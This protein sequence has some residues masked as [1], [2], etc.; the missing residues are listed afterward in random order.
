MIGPYPIRALWR[1][2]RNAKS[3]KER[4]DT[5]YFAWEAS[6]RLGVA[7]RP[8]AELGALTMPS[9]G[10]WV[11]AL[12]VEDRALDN[13]AL[14]ATAALMTE[15]AQGK[16]S[17][18]HRVAARKLLDGLA[19]YRNAII[20]H[21]ST[22]TVEF[23]D[24]AARRLL[25][26]LER[27]WALGLFL[28]ADA[29]LCFV[30]SVEL[31]AGGD[32]RGRVFDL[33][34]D[35]PLLQHAEG[36]R[37]APDVLPGRLYLRCGDEHRP[38]HPWLLYEAAELRE[39]VLFFNGRAR[40]S[41][42][43]DYVGGENLKGKALVTRFPAVE[44]D[45]A[46]LFSSAPTRAPAEASEPKDPNVFGEYRL[47][48][49]LGQGGMGVVYLAQQQSLGRLVALKVQAAETLD[50]PVARARFDREV[51]ALSRCD[52]PNVVKILASG[53]TDGKPYYVMELV[54]GADL[55]QLAA[56][57][58]S[59]RTLDAAITTAAGGV[60]E[61]KH[62]AFADVPVV[63]RAAPVVDASETPARR[64][65]GLCLLFRDA[66]RALDALHAAGVLHRDIKPAN[67]MVT[68]VDRRVVVIDLGLA[69][70]SD[71][72]RG[73]TQ[74]QGSLLGTLR[75]MAPEQLQR[76]LL[77]LDPRADLY[78]L[79]ATFYELFTSR[80]FHDGTTEAQLVEQ[81]LYQAPLAPRKANAAIPVDLATI[82]E[83][84][85]QKDRGQRYQTAAALERDIEAFLQGRP[86]S[87]RRPTLFYRASLA[88]R[89]NKGAILVLAAATALAVGLP[90]LH[91][92]LTPHACA[93]GDLADCTVQCAKHHAGSCYTL[94]TMV[95][96]GSAA[97]RDPARA[98]QLF[99]EACDGGSGP[100]CHRLG[101]MLERGDAGPRDDAEARGR[102]ERA[103][104]LGEPQGCTSLAVLLADGRGGPVDEARA[105]ALYNQACEAHDRIACSNLGAH[106]DRGRGVAAD[107][108]RARAL[109][110]KA[111][112]AGWIPSCAILAVDYVEGRGGP[113][114]EAQ[115]ATLFDRACAAGQ[116]PACSG[117]AALKERGA[118]TAKD[119]P[120]AAELYRRACE[121]EPRACFALGR[122]YERGE[123]VGADVLR[124]IGLFARVC[125]AS[126]PDG[127]AELG[128]LLV[129]GRGIPRDLLHGTELLRKG[130][131]G[132]VKTACDTLAKVPRP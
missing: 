128:V 17:A 94:G 131:E 121:G 111:C 82:L 41:Q 90:A 109:H 77:G 92:R 51:R 116:L 2:A 107:P 102:H 132:G 91:T 103:C 119:L 99:R 83:K 4:H 30:E 76:S 88:A 22:R 31:D 6:V 44:E 127:C 50:D 80:P 106:Y 72:S 113:R 28:P 75:Y 23:Y 21:G 54:E 118:G 61:A 24:D 38:L 101:T 67:L 29:R 42:Y 63:A 87:A 13:P 130:C 47:L 5:A 78:S 26:G 43:L 14:I 36:Q 16:A 58:G 115:A 62:T 27:A 55:A 19:A 112:G 52:H 40:S 59:A 9:T 69:A 8:P 18:P 79:G 57:L 20:G 124:A 49:K 46:A 7:A 10:H 12:Q 120:G 60:R 73:L 56:A 104:S 86:I 89:R 95:N 98:A 45:V 53:E 129:E 126:I 1:R 35:A 65:E 105:V 84:T 11:A 100:A 85:T 66:A 37:L 110:D 123:G 70:L 117:L 93:M 25:D 3:P 74:D 15:A 33:D 122:M 97:P 96:Q 114:D 108:A 48:G 71:A 125:E 68:S 34:G 32:H 64:I 39:R 81:V